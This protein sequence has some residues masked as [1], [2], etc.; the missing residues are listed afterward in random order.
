M[1]KWTTLEASIASNQPLYG[2]KK[3]IVVLLFSILGVMIPFI[4]LF[5]A[6]VQLPL[7]MKMNMREIMPIDY[8][9]LLPNA[10]SF[11][12]ACYN[13]YLLNKLDAAFLRSFYLS[14]A[15][16]PIISISVLLIWATNQSIPLNSDKIVEG[17]LSIIF[18]WAL[19]TLIWLPY[20]LLSKRVNLTLLHRVKT[21]NK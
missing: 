2:I 18:A 14:L 20:F 3:S 5:S 6:V 19:W 13:L 10:I 16:C 15:V 11:V 21:N 4:G 9:L 17:A 1:N 12:W 7:I 8:L